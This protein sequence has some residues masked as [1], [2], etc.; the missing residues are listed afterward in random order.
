ML[1]QHTTSAFQAVIL[2]TLSLLLAIPA[3]AADHAAAPNKG[4][5]YLVGLGTGDAD[6]MTIRARDTIARADII[7]A[8]QGVR[9][10]FAELFKGKAVYDSGHGLFGRMAKKKQPTRE[11]QAAKDKTDPAESTHQALTK[12]NRKPP[13]EIQK[14]QEETRKIIREAVAAGKT[15]AVLDNGDPMIFGPHVGYLQEFADLAPEVVPGL[16]SFNAANAALKRDVTRGKQS[17][18]VILT[19]A[20]GA[21]EGYQGKDSLAKLAE[22]QSSLVF[23]T[24][25][26][27]LAEVVDVLKKSYPADT[28]MAIVFHAGSKKEEQVLKATLETI[29]QET[30]GRE[31]PFEHLIYVGDFLQ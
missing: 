4:K 3:Q 24:M 5:L 22:S 18:S 20:R 1:F 30:K 13:K 9:D 2:I 29:V 27:N 16:S 19:A 7:F 28:P 31:L 17:S 12:R 21:R 23:Y 26:M 11:V 14:Q 15:V 10:E 6:N 25:G 8:M